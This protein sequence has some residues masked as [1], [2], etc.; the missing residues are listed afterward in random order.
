MIVLS[1]CQAVGGVDLNQVLNNDLTIT[2]YESSSEFEIEIKVRDDA[3]LTEEEAKILN[4]LNGTSIVFDE[5][6]VQDFTTTSASGEVKINGQTLPF[7]FFMD[8][9][10]LAFDIEGAKK[11]IVISEAG[12]ELSLDVIAIIEQWLNS[13]EFSEMVSEVGG[14]YVKHFPNPSSVQVTQL[15]ESIHGELTNLT[16]IEL[17]VKGNEIIPLIQQFLNNMLEDEEGLKETFG[18]IYDAFLPIFIEAINQASTEAEK[19]EFE[20]ILPY[21]ENKELAVNFLFTAIQSNAAPIVEDLEKNLKTWT[22]EDLFNKI[23]NENNVITVAYYVDNNGNTRKQDLNLTLAFE[24]G[25]I[26]KMEINN[27]NVIWNLNG[28]VKADIID[29]TDSYNFEEL[30]FSG[31]IKQAFEEDSTIYRWMTKLEQMI[32]EEE[33]PSSVVFLDMSGETQIPGL[34]AQPYVENGITMVPVRYVS[35]QLEATVN[36]NQETRQVTITDLA[37]GQSIVLTV[38]SNIAIVNG[39]TIEL[40]KPAEIKEGSVF[41]PLRFIAESLG[42]EVTWDSELQLIIIVR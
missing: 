19:A 11:P 17:Q 1:G 33:L 13:K 22:N 28:D 38:D 23:F 20:E 39:E 31:D 30:L 3:E 4:I 32:P 5:I 12:D 41:V 10:T 14:F 37:T 16:K 40:Q 42:A 18:V 34:T 9:Y 8:E 27:T 26:E 15:S 35:E 21:L 24:E 2:S 36:W 6:K 25:I 29:T 7:T